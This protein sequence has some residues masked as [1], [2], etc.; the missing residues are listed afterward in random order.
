MW[1]KVRRLF[2]FDSFGAANSTLMLGLVLPFF[3]GYFGMPPHVLYALA[4]CALFLTFL[5]GIC[6]FVKP[7]RWR[8]FLRVIATM[9]IA[10]CI[11][12]VVFVYLFWSSLTHLG[13]IYFIIEKVVVLILAAIE[14]NV[15][16][17]KFKSVG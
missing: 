16:W 5:S 4:A 15:S 14:I 11:L 7:K 1:K 3:S 2:L 6:F 12:S 8:F 9:N 10:Y 17:R 13:V